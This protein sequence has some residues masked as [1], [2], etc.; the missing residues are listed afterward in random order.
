MKLIVSWLVNA[1]A[2]VIVSKIIPGIY[3]QDF[4]VAMFAGLIFILF[5]VSLK[6]LILL[7]T[8]PLNLLSLGIFTLFINGFLF[9]LVSK[10][11]GGFFI[12]G[13]WSAFWGALFFSITNFVLNIFM[14]PWKKYRVNFYGT[15]SHQSSRH[16]NAIDAEIVPE[17]EKNKKLLKE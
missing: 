14:N 16:N 4:S 6:P 13:F 10:M 9:Y 11:I 7:V 12:S 5:N 1:I 3:V 8:L 15:K 2:L 17:K